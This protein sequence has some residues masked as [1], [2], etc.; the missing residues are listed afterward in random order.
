M[1]NIKR[2]LFRELIK[3]MG[4]G[5]GA[6]VKSSGELKV[7]KVVEKLFRNKSN[8]LFFDVGGHVGTY[9]KAL[10]E[11]FGDSISIH[12]FEPSPETYKLFLESTQEIS[13]INP[14][15]FGFSSEP[16]KTIFI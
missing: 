7:L 4:Y 2:F 12:A 9:S 5:I 16:K 15:N 6:N 10:A 8:L 3:T 14:N 13:N 11:F 1:Q